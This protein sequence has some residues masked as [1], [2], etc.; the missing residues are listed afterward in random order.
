MIRSALAIVAGVATLT[1]I[2]FAI[3][4]V[5]DPLLMRA[6]PESLPTRAAFAHNLPVTLFGFAYGVLS[7]AAGGYVTAWIARR[8]PL[9][10]AAILGGVQ[11]LLTLWAMSAIG[12]HAPARNWIATLIITL[13]ASLLGGWLFARR[14]S[15]L[16]TTRAT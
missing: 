3:E 11:I 15:E 14:A 13:P 8:A 10:H 4:L 5:A 12:N 6:F 1:A 16:T 7:I 2:S 9:L